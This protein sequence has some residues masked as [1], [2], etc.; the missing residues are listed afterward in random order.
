MN[1]RSRKLSGPG[2]DAKILRRQ[3]IRAKTILPQQSAIRG[4]FMSSV[5]MCWRVERRSRRI[6]E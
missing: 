4:V 3:R 1:R 6:S 5:A 2:G